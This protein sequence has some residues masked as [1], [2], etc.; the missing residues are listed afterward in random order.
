M[1]H[2]WF[3]KTLVENY[4]FIFQNSKTYYD[5][6]LYE[7]S[8]KFPIPDCNKLTATLQSDQQHFHQQ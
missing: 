8:F 1:I 2:V 6:K 5:M 7:T 3:V 4:T